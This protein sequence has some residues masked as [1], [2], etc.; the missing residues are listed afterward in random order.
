MFAFFGGNTNTTIGIIMIVLFTI[1]IIIW[2]IVSF[3]FQILLII[4]KRRSIQVK[5]IVKDGQIVRYQTQKAIEDAAAS[6][7]NNGQ[8]EEESFSKAI[9]DPKSDPKAEMKSYPQFEA[10]GHRSFYGN[11]KEDNKQAEDQDEQRG[12]NKFVP[13][14]PKPNDGSFHNLEM[15]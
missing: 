13:L 5:E 12:M 11:F 15:L 7:G 3:I 6:K 9:I 2:F 1:N 4:S 10:L 14:H 8:K